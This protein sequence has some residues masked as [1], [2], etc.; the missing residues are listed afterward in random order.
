MLNDKEKYEQ[1]IR[2]LEKK[3][4]EEPVGNGF[5]SEFKDW[6]TVDQNRYN[7][8]LDLVHKL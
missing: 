4:K 8:L 7:D 6:S 3:N 2:S 1:E 5:F